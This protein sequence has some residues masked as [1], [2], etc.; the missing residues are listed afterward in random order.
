LK[1][2]T[3]D[4]AGAVESVQQFEREQKTTTA[5]DSAKDDDGKGGKLKSWFKEKIGRRLSRNAQ[6]LGTVPVTKREGEEE[7]IYGEQNPIVASNWA[8][9]HV[10]RDD[11]LKNVALARDSHERRKSVETTGTADD[12]DDD[13]FKDAQEEF[14]KDLERPF[15]NVEEDEKKESTERG[16]RFKEEF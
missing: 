15:L 16:S 12:D 9:G 2:V 4:Q 10:P 6:D 5:D 8:E 11:S 3:S 14:N 7:D 1:K 13:D